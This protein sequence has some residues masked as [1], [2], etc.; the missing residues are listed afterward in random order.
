MLSAVCMARGVPGS[1]PVT[2]LCCRL[3]SSE[4][5]E[6]AVVPPAWIWLERHANA[7]SIAWDHKTYGPK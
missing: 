7:E 2:A 5:V 3:N 1:E 6:N 4:T